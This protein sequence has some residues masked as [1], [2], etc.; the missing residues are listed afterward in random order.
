MRVVVLEEPGRFEIVSCD[1]PVESQ[2]D[3]LVRVHRVG[4]C[5]TDLHAYAGRQPFFDYPRILGHELA[6]EVL[7]APRESALLPGN[8]CAVEPYLTC[9]ECSACLADRSNCCEHMQ[10]LGVHVDGGMAP[11]M[12]IPSK[13]LH[14]SSI[15]SLDQLA[16]VETLGIG[17]HAV[18][19]ADLHGDERVLVVGAGPIGLA[20][21][22]FAIL[23]G[24]E[25]HVLEISGARREFASRFG[26]D[27]RDNIGDSK[28]DVVFDATGNQN[29]MQKSFA[30]LE[31]GAKLIFAGFI[32]GEITFDDTEFHRR[33]VTLMSSRNSTNQFPRII[34]LIES[35]RVDTSP[36]IT[37]RMTLAEVAEDFASL[38]HSPGLIKAM[39]TVEDPDVY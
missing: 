18:A 15:L 36:W 3:V 5:G 1:A 16:L 9:G 20:V 38:P 12:N 7:R 29:A 21:T 6:V 8:M 19:R 34:E 31:Q 32:Q 2:G 17:A 26:A 35:G 30:F 25:V 23:T 11:I 22:Q 24:T 28:Y 37:H 13:L 39:V 10:V 33:E 14:Q 27:A 4:V